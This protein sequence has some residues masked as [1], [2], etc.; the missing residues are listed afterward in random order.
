M[1]AIRANNCLCHVPRVSQKADSGPG[2]RIYTD[3]DILAPG[4]IHAIEQALEN[5]SYWY[6]RLGQVQGEVGRNGVTFLQSDF[7]QLPPPPENAL[8]PGRCNPGFRGSE[9]ERRIFK[10]A[11][12]AVANMLDAWKRIEDGDVL[13]YALKELKISTKRLMTLASGLQTLPR[14]HDIIEISVIKYRYDP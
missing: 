13:A 14:M 9:L 4:G 10:A 11:F 8:K 3:E 6:V 5:E 12:K 1:A 2:Q 7:D